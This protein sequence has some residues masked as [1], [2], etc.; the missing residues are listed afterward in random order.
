MKKNLLSI[1]TLL[2]ITSPV[3]SQCLTVACPSNITT[4]NVANACSAIVNYSAPVVVNSCISAAS[5]TFAFT[6]SVQSYVVP[7]GVTSLTLEAWGA[8]GGANWV[9]NVNYG[10]YAK[11]VFTVVPGQTLQLFVGGQPTTTAGGFN[12]GGNGDA[13]GKGGGG[14]TDV[15]VS[16][17]SLTDRIIVAGGGGGAGF[18]SLLHVVGGFG[19]GLVGGDGYR[20]T[21]AN[22][23][24]LGA[25]QTAG[26]LHGTCSSFSNT[27]MAGSFAIGG[28]ASGFS[29]GCEGYGGGGGWY[30][31]AASGNCRGGGGGSGYLLPTATGTNFLSGVNIGNGKIVITALGAT[32]FTNTLISGLS[33]GSSFSIGTTVQTFTVVDNSNNSATCSFSV[34]VSDVQLPNLVCPLN[35]TA[36]ATSSNTTLSSLA[37]VTVSDNCSA[38]LSYSL[39]GATTGSGTGNANGLFNLGVTNIIYRA[40]DPSGNFS[41]CNFSVTVNA[42]PTLTVASTNSTIC[43]GQQVTLTASGANTYSWNTTA[44]TSAVILSP[45]VTI[46]YTVTG[47]ALTC[48]A[49]KVFTQTVNP[50][51]TINA[52]TNT[53]LLCVGSTASIT[54][55]GA[56]TY[57]WNT[58][59]NGAIIAV[60]P[61]VTTTY[62]VNGTSTAGCNNLATITQSVSPCT[63]IKNIATGTAANVL[64]YPNPSKGIFVVDLTSSAKV[65]VTD[66]VGKLVYTSKLNEGKQTI[67]LTNL[68]N[69]IYILKAESNGAVNAVKLIKE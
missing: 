54:A 2:A 23:G 30:G 57:T 22:P 4:I 11:G 21:P 43:A 66:V 27:A 51:P 5:T 62:T 16:P 12:G 40:I 17:Y 20:D 52:I 35:L 10:G 53:S 34:T 25:T 48:T 6:G 50:N 49:S 3:H 63:G 47:T 32:N 55:S 31:G 19:G 65:I 24:G 44:T 45:T 29:C 13:A 61:T 37:P 46:T 69:G 1:F 28:N 67:N 42:S 26:G 8:Q 18:W 7:S 41:T 14:G 9:N 56:N 58:S 39:L 60:S 59:A 68:P 33:S 64:V 38:A 36:C 15:R